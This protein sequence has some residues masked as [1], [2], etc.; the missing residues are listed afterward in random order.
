MGSKKLRLSNHPDAPI[1][2]PPL[3]VLLPVE[4]QGTQAATWVWKKSPTASP[5][6][7]C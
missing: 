3:P 4:L 5:S 7:S 6:A 2:F 1:Y